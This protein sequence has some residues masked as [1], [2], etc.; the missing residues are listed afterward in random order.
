[1]SVICAAIKD[2]KIAIGCD[3]QISFSALRVTSAHIANA[4]KLHQVNGS[5][6]GIVGWNTLSDMVEHLTIHKPELFKLSNRMEIY[7]TLLKLHQIMKKDYFLSTKANEDKQPVESSQFNAIIINK[8]G[9]FE[10][11]KLREVNQYHQ[12]WSVGS[13]RQYALGAM[14][15]IYPTEPSAAKIVAAGLTAGCE[16]DKGC[17]LPINIEKITLS[18][19]SC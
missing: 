13:G 8:H 17:S 16:F 18:M 19:G 6:I 4:N 15:A 5:I 3:T 1:M 12:Y 10:I 2:G 14:Q 7:S 11:S 9:L